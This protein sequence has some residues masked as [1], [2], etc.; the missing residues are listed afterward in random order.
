MVIDVAPSPRSSGPALSRKIVAPTTEATVKKAR[1]LVSLA[2]LPMILMVSPAAMPFQ[3][4]LVRVIVR[5]APSKLAVAMM[6]APR[7]KDT[8]ARSAALSETRSSSVNDPPRMMVV[9]PVVA[10]MSVPVMIVMPEAAMF[11]CS[12]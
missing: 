5:A 7:T 4:P 8:S 3:L 9:W 12:V 2:V 11:S 6:G 10:P 1:P